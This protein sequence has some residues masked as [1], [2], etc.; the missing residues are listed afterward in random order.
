MAGTQENRPRNTQRRRRKVSPL[1]FVIV[2]AVIIILM[3]F[4][5][6]VKTIEVVGSSVYTPEEIISAS[7]IQEGDNLF[8][9]NK[10][11]ATSQILSKLPAVDHATVDRA[12][13]SRIIISIIESDSIAYIDIQGEKWALDHSMRFLEKLGA[14]ET[15]DRI[16][17]RGITAES[18]IIGTAVENSEE[19][20]EM[21]ELMGKYS[22]LPYISWLELGDDSTAQFDYLGRFTVKMKLDNEIDMSFQKLLSAV[23]QLSTGDRALLD[24][25]QDDKV[26][27]LPR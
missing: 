2:C 9:I 8:F 11:T 7:G 4:M 19:I 1:P 17:I 15:E 5:F 6:R 16:E 22:M 25:S 10:F 23:S 18:P 14:D 12:L 3:S 26:H 24:L 27:Y 20:S 13:P 21:L